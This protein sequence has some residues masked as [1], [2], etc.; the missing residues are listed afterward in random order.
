MSFLTLATETI[1]YHPGFSWPDADLSH[2]RDGNAP[3]E[4]ARAH[5]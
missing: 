3:G 4:R 2:R 5:D 1:R